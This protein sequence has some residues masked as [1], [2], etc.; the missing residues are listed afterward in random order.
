MLF[1]NSFRRLSNF[2]QHSCQQFAK[3]RREYPNYRNHVSII[4]GDMS[5]IGLG[6][7]DTHRQLLAET[8]EIVLH[9][10]AEV[11]FNDSL[12][13]LVTINLRGTRQMLQLAESFKKL[14]V[15]QFA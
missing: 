4:E 10:A 1:I 13:K 11:R 5:I 8:V 3:L 6:I 7:S 12:H 14:Q 9:A 2:E 15:N